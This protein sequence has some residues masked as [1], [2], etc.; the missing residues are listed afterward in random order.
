MPSQDFDVTSQTLLK[1]DSMKN[2]YH[3]EYLNARTVT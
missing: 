1:D 3:L 2:D